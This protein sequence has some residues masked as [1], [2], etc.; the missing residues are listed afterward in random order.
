MR[1]GLISNVS[2][3]AWPIDV[4]RHR[5]RMPG[6]ALTVKDEAIGKELASSSRCHGRGDID[7]ASGITPH[8]ATAAAMRQPIQRHIPRMR[9]LTSIRGPWLADGA[10]APAADLGADLGH[11]V[12]SNNPSS[13]SGMKRVRA[14]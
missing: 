1:S 5:S 7:G 3:E 9:A 4:L 14:A 10:A 12:R 8:G 11:V 2:F 13:R 6:F